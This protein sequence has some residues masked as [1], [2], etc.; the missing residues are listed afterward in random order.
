ML[1]RNYNCGIVGFNYV[2]LIKGIIETDP[3]LAE[4]IF[5]K[6]SINMAILKRDLNKAIEKYPTVSNIEK[7]YLTSDANQSLARAS[8]SI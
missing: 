2:S 7:Q 6:M 5:N 3:K 8:S 1:R 4:F